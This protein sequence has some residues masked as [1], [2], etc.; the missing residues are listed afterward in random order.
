MNPIKEITEAEA[1]NLAGDA[2]E[3]PVLMKE[4]DIATESAV[5]LKKFPTGYVLGVSCDTAAIFKL[6]YAENLE[7][8]NSLCEHYL[9]ILRKKGNPFL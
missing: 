8:I 1:F 6:F 9:N 4:E 7:E 5:T 3:F 2:T